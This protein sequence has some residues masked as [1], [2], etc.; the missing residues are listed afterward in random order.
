MKTVLIFN[1][2]TFPQQY[3]VYCTNI[4]TADNSSGKHSEVAVCYLIIYYI[5]TRGLPLHKVI[6]GKHGV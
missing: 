5:F 2:K 3:T 6:M 4:M 1:L